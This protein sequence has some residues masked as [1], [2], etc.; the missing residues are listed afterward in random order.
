LKF[1]DR[2]KNFREEKVVTSEERTR[3]SRFRG[4]QTQDEGTIGQRGG[5]EIYAADGGIK[6]ARALNL[7]GFGVKPGS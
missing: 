7:D 5:R 3:G 4:N 2:G 6:M 1:H